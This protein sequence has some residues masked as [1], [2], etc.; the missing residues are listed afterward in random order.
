MEPW[1]KDL[2]ARIRKFDLGQSDSS[3]TPPVDKP[4]YEEAYDWT[5][6]TV[7]GSEATA[8]LERRNI[9][10][11]TW[12]NF[13]RVWDASAG[14][15]EEDRLIQYYNQNPD[16]EFRIDK[17]GRLLQLPPGEEQWS[18]INA[19]GLDPSDIAEM[20][21]ELSSMAGGTIGLFTGRN[22]ANLLNKYKGLG[23]KKFKFLAGLAGMIYG[24][25]EGGERQIT[26]AEE[27]GQ[28]AHL[29]PEEIKK[30]RGW[31][32]HPGKMALSE[33]LGAL[34]GRIITGAAK[35]LWTMARGVDIPKSMR[36]RALNIPENM[37]II[38]E[39]V[40]AMLKAAGIN[41][42]FSPDSARI[43][44]DPEFMSAVIAIERGG[45]EA[46]HRIV[47]QLYGNNQDA[48][49][50]FLELISKKQELPTTT[51]IPGKASPELQVGETIQ[52]AVRQEIGE[53]EEAVLKAAQDAASG[54]LATRTG[55]E[56]AGGVSYRELGEILRPEVKAVYDDLVASMKLQF[57]G[58]EKEVLKTQPKFMPANT[59]RVATEL[60][61]KLGKGPARGTALSE[62][63]DVLVT[64]IKENVSSIHGRGM[65]NPL[66]YQEITDYIKLL[67]KGIRRSQKASQ[68]GSGLDLDVLHQLEKA[69]V[70]DRKLRLDGMPN[71]LAEK[72]LAL[73]KAYSAQKTLLESKGVQNIVAWDAHGPKLQDDQ[74]FKRIF[75]GEGGATR[76]AAN[77]VI[78]LLEK[79]TD[80]GSFEAIRRAIFTDFV[81]KST[82]DEGGEIIPSKAVN[83]LRTH[84][85]NLK[86]WLSA[87]E[88][89][90]LTN[91]KDSGK[92]L[93]QARTKAANW[94]KDMKEIFGPEYVRIKNGEAAD[95]FET[96]WKNASSII[97]HKELLQD[98]YPHIWEQLHNSGLRNIKRD[99][100]DIDEVAKAARDFKTVNQYNKGRR[101]SEQLTKTEFDNWKAREGETTESV[102][103]DRLRKQLSDYKWVDK[104]R[105]V[106]GDEY[107]SN[108]IK[109]RNAAEILGRAPGKV[110]SDPTNPMVEML[111]AVGFGPLSHKR[112]AFKA[113]K[114]YAENMQN[115]NFADLVLDPYALNRAAKLATTREGMK[116]VQQMLGGVAGQMSTR[117]EAYNKEAAIDALTTLRKDI[118]LP[119]NALLRDKI[120]RALTAGP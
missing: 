2:K 61:A 14:P 92:L 74:L 50:E 62:G 89:K 41:K 6:E 30:K 65:A 109:L 102:S 69:A 51:P 103:Y 34:G 96:A 57:E 44:N 71:N 54:E 97:K 40:N 32:G 59:L 79:G 93:K 112:F 53:G 24:A 26:L 99:L 70:L 108:L 10:T 101:K 73:E 105:A 63:E 48:L 5:K 72:H 55:V 25:K 88:I 52:T 18:V 106:Y 43:L 49:R 116:Q 21:G 86:T 22:I 84:K 118:N 16:L 36:E 87:D 98:K 4:W 17:T 104:V 15:D 117:G 85:E 1:E 107:I 42:K 115:Q 94:D 77:N 81:R 113:M 82:I 3:A 33:G 75:G 11:S 27:S 38:I 67:R 37:P 9:D 76:G 28:L 95:I 29:T 45:G 120:Q 110:K 68:V 64:Q 19:P 23:G 58:L 46:G 39:E 90:T 100:L 47:R 66:T 56:S 35:K 12:K 13:R 78:S 83:W 91:A 60:Q 119:G 20:G 7:L 31:S 80:I 111:S 114:K 8:D